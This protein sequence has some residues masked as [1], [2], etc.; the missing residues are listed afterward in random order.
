MT[1]TV[2]SVYQE[3]LAKTLRDK[4]TTLNGQMDKVINDANS[5]LNVLNQKLDSTTLSALHFLTTDPDS[6][7]EVGLGQ[8]ENGEHQ[9]RD[10]LP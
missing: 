1:L 9:P 6:R 5:E 3:Y 4:Y 2:S 10:S 8:A 7:C